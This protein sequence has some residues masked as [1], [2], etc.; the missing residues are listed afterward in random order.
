[1]LLLQWPN[2]KYYALAKARSKQIK[3]QPRH[4]QS[5]TAWLLMALLFLVGMMSAAMPEGLT[6]KMHIVS[7]STASLLH[8][9]TQLR[10]SKDYG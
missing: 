1:V 7:S 6:E 8:L 9:G 4:R 5:P 10:D 2:G 3:T